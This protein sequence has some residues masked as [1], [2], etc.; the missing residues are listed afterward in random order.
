MERQYDIDAM[1]FIA[2]LMVVLLHGIEPGE[3]VQQAIYLLGSYAIPLFFLINGYLLADKTIDLSFANSRCLRYLRFIILWALLLSIPISIVNREVEVLQVVAKSLLGKG[4]LFHFWFLI[5]LVV[6]YYIDSVLLKRKVIPQMSCYRLFAVSCVMLTI[7]FCVILTLKK[8]MGIEVREIIPAYFRIVTNGSYFFLG[9][10]LKRSFESTGSMQAFDRHSRKIWGGVF[11]CSCLGTMLLANLTHIQWASTMYDSLPVLLGTLALFML[12]KGIK[13]NFS[14]RTIRLLQTSGGI[15][16]LHPFLLK[17]INKAGY[18][19][20]GE[21]M[22]L[23]ALEWKILTVVLAVTMSAL[24]TLVMSK[25]KWLR[26]L[27]KP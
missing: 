19:F 18:I 7:T 22:W 6:L 26:M 10:L 23:N 2:C 24:L 25:N 17:A 12:V 21:Q 14:V 5:A 4:Y 20:I 1:K 3:G 16:I 15:W 11:V 8:N 27:V 9:R 13:F